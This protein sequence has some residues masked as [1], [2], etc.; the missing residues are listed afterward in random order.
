MGAGRRGHEAPVPRV[1][2]PLN[3]PGSSARK[4]NNQRSRPCRQDS[5]GRILRSAGS[6]P[7][8]AVRSQ[9]NDNLSVGSV[10]APANGCMDW[11]GQWLEES[12]AVKSRTGEAS[13]AVTRC[14]LTGGR[15]LGVNYR[16]AGRGLRAL[17]LSDGAMFALFGGFRMASQG[18]VRDDG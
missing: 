17:M 13:V 8:R 5:N 7:S 15:P 12:T 1:A 3:A 16:A 9:A 18:E 11:A 4:A 2:G 10:G 6:T 14:S